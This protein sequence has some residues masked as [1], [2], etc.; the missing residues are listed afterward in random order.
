M[1]VASLRRLKDSF[2]Q[3]CEMKAS[4]HSI[5]LGA[6]IGVFV[7]FLP[8]MGIQ[9]SIAVPLA[10]LLRANKVLAAAGVWLTNPITFIPI[11]YSCYLAGTV[12]Y[13]VEP[14]RMAAFEALAED[15]TVDSFLHLGERIVAP[16]LI[17]C[18]V[19][20]LL[21]GLLTYVVTRRLVLN[22]RLRR[23]KQEEREAREA[24]LRR[25]DPALSSESAPSELER[26]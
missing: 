18:V 24:D 12:I 25:S 1:P 21:F 2:L 23:A 17:G 14:I 6:A 8:C 26:S 4:A 22:V 7:G 19:L 13:R 5:A 10:F 20:G 15:F 11:Y 9:M 3:I 16:M